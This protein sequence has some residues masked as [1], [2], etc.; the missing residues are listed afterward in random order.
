MAQSPQRGIR[1]PITGFFAIALNKCRRDCG[2]NG[3]WM[4]RAGA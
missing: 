4:P 3:V 2:D 1:T